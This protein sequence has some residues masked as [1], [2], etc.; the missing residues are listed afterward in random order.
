MAAVI[1]AGTTSISAAK[2]PA[3]SSA[4]QASQTHFA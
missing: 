2:A 1:A 4:A 3:C